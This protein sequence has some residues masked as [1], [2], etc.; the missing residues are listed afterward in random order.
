MLIR[1]AAA[2]D[3]FA[4]YALQVRHR[5]REPAE[6]AAVQPLQDVAALERSCV[7]S[8]VL[9]AIEDG[10]TVASV[11]ADIRDGAV[12]AD[13]PWMADPATCRRAA[14]ALLLELER[15]CADC[16][17]FRIET[18]QHSAKTVNVYT[19]AG[20]TLTGEHPVGGRLKRYV[21]A[22]DTSYAAHVEW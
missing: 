8:M 19:K 16:R 9:I 7:S 1:R 10:Q 6:V 22:K 4:L 15:R 14:A 5:G 18:I 13:A 11:R 12:H 2:A 3:A 21:Y 17:H 20:Y